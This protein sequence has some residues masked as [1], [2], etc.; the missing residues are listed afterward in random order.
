MLIGVGSVSKPRMLWKQIAG[1]PNLIWETIEDFPKKVTSKPNQDLKDEWEFSRHRE[2]SGEG[3][4]RKREREREYMSTRIP[5]YAR[6][7]SQI[8]APRGHRGKER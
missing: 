7:S 8:T 3:K 1:K 4:K 6:I 2:R 5:K